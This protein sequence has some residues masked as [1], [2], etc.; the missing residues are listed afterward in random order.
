MS[1]CLDERNWMHHGR[2]VGPDSLQ[3]EEQVPV[4]VLEPRPSLAGFG[5]PHAPGC[6]LLTSLPSA[7]PLSLRAGITSTLLSA[8]GLPVC[9]SRSAQ[10]AR[11]ASKNHSSVKRLRKVAV[12][13]SSC[14]PALSTLP[15]HLPLGLP[16]PFFLGP[17]LCSQPLHFCAQEQGS[18]F[19]GLPCLILG[20]V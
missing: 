10:P 8:I 20:S 7:C 4:A 5:A 3:P 9:L 11:T 15:S 19:P 6:R 14:T 13:G 12:K 18:G 1:R 17:L 2:L 16:P